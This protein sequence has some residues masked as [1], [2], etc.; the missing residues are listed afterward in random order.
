MALLGLRSG[1]ALRALLLGSAQLRLVG[2]IRL[3][4]L[5]ARPRASD[6]MHDDLPALDAALRAPAAQGVVK[7]PSFAKAARYSALNSSLLGIAF[8]SAAAINVL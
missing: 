4:I 2:R 7:L 8:Q 3:V 5:A 1:R 6:G